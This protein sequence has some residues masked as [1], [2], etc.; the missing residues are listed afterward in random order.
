MRKRTLLGALAG[1]AVVVAIGALASP[2]TPE[3]TASALRANFH[4]IAIHGVS[5][6][7]ELLSI[8][9]RPG[10]YTTGPTTVTKLVDLAA[11]PND[12]LLGL[13][14]DSWK[15]DTVEVTPQGELDGSVMLVCWTV[16]KSPQGPLG[17]LLWRLKRQW[18]RWF[19][20]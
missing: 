1:L 4:R 2:L 7:A 15:T 11:V 10:D 17:N 18:H 13:P 5:S 3:P 16:T 19:P 9:G 20:E 8:L 14:A 6:Q 12:Y